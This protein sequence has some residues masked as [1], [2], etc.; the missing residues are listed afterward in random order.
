MFQAGPGKLTVIFEVTANETN[1]GAMLDLFGTGSRAI[2]SNVLAQGANGGSERVAKSITLAKK[3]EIVIRIKGL[4]Y[5][6][7]GGYPG[8][9]KLRLEGPAVNFD[10]V[11]PTEVTTPTEAQAQAPPNN[12][13]QNKAPENV[14]PPDAVQETTPAEPAPAV[15]GPAK[16]TDKVDRA[17][18]KG[19]TKAQT[20]LDLIDKVK[21][22]KP[23]Q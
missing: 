3:Q 23:N 20:I 15:A 14:P 4:S 18:E 6:S 21:P 12:P 7:S 16:K 9:Y 11:V 8:I 10:Q 5:G 2:M 13:D 19:K 1:A 22:K 17:I